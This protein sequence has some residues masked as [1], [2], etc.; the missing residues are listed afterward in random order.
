MYEFLQIDYYCQQCHCGVSRSG[1][2]VLEPPGVLLVDPSGQKNLAI[3]EAAI[4]GHLHLEEEEEEGEQK[5][6]ILM[7]SFL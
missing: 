2:L 3:E 5:H 4:S 7:M 1:G 6:I